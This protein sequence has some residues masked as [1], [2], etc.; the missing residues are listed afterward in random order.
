MTAGTHLRLLLDTHVLLWA[1][2]GDPRLSGPVRS[3]IIDGSTEVAVSAASAWEIAIKV[4]LGKL[5]APDDLETALGQARF[6]PLPI[7]IKHALA[8]GALPRH[9]DDPFDRVLVAQAG[10]DGYQLVSADP[11]MAAYDIVVLSP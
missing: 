6:R 10:V 3:Q 4:A 9:H 2:A 8:A 11:R 5:V 7:S 1:L